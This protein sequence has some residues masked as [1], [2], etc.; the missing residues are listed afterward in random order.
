MQNAQ[1]KFLE[2]QVLLNS[3]EKAGFGFR[4]SISQWANPF[5]D[6]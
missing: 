5:S 4:V 6:P 1:P 2:W 3:A